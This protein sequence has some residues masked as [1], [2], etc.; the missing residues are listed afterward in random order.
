MKRIARARRAAGLLALILAAAGVVPR[1][2]LAWGDEGHEIIGLIAAQALRPDVRERVAALLATDHSGLTRGTGIAVQSTW[3]DRYRNLH[4]RTG[5]WH[6]VNLEL[7]RPDLRTACF[8]ERPL[9]PGVAA[10]RGPAKDC[11]VDKVRQFNRELAAAATAPAERLRA[12]Q[13]LLHLVGDL[14]QPLHCADDHDRGGNDE[15]TLIAGRP[16]GSLHHDW[17]TVFV[18]KLGRSPQRVAARLVRRISPAERRRWSAGTPA[19]WALQSH[20]VAVRIAYGM[21][22]R[23]D[24]RGRYRLDAAYVAAAT[25]ATRSQLERAGVRL[26]A[27]LNADLRR[28]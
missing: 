12:L 18:A 24:A 4:P 2:A 9:P 22:P 13:F 14:H 17:D 26:A 16:A 23:P 8:G 27:L 11:V 10:S 3:A 5:R 15:R 19:D 20:A 28:R 21:L 1:D 6:Y 7:R 25:A